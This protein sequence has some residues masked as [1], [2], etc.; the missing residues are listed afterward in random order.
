MGLFTSETYRS[1]AIGFG[2]GA[3]VLFGSLAAQ[4]QPAFSPKLIP[5]AEAAPALPD[6]TR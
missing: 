6:N 1:F 4:G 2:L 3:V 5:T